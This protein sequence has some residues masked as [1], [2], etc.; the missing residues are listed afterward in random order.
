MGQNEKGFLW[1]LRQWRLAQG[2]FLQMLRQFGCI[3]RFSFGGLL[4]FRLDFWLLQEKSNSDQR[5][6]LMCT[7]C[8]TLQFTCGFVFCGICTIKCLFKLS[9]IAKALSQPVKWQVKSR[10]PS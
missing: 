5:L 3:R 10:F 8:I 9:S 7:K 6:Q 2:D 1:K 4:A